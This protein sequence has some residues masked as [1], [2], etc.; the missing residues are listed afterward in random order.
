MLEKAR[1]TEV[2]SPE[3]IAEGFFR[4]NQTIERLIFKGLS[5]EAKK[6]QNSLIQNCQFLNCS[7]EG[8]IFDA[9]DFQRV[10][11]DEC[12]IKSC[13]FANEFRFITGTLNRVRLEGVDFT[14]GNVQNVKWLDCEFD[15]VEFGLDKGK[16]L[17][18][19]GSRFRETTFGG[20]HLVGC[21]FRGTAGLERSLFYAAKIDDCAFDWNEAFIIME[22]GNPLADNLYTYGIEP[23]VRKAGFEPKRVDKYE[24]KGRITDEILQNIITCQIAVAECSAANKNVFFEIGF[25]LGNKRDVIFLV[26]EAANIPFDLKDFKFIIHHNSIDALVEQLKPRLEY[27]V[28]LSK[29]PRDSDD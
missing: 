29:R 23:A 10:S 14:V 22:F 20:T 6:F 5:F 26:D 3:E 12:S 13:I 21:D 16:S 25:A 9:M 19:R 15:R 17:T 18:F 1:Y 8:C 28:K 11:F 4:D 7:F 24:F 2:N 27:F